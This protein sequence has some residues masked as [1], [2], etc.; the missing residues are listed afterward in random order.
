[1]TGS[2]FQ[3]I[4]PIYDYN[5]KGDIRTITDKNSPFYGDKIIKEIKFRNAEG[6]YDHG[7]L[8]MNNFGNFSPS[9]INAFQHALQPPK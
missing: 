1:M 3:V 7:A 4:D 6:G 9:I 8:S 5:S 2:I